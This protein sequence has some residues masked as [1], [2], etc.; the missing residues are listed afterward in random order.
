MLTIKALLLHYSALQIVS[1][2]YREI[3]V[4]PTI[5]WK[6]RLLRQRCSIL[7]ACPPRPSQPNNFRSRISIAIRDFD[8]CMFRYEVAFQALF[9][10]Q[11]QPF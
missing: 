2:R 4:Y 3:G 6:G 1:F 10:R 8:P 5:P 7:L 11:H 9:F